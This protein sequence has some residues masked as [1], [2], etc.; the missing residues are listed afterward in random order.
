MYVIETINYTVDLIKNIDIPISIY[1][2]RENNGKYIMERLT[3]KNTDIEWGLEYP[4][5]IIECKD[6]IYHANMLFGE[7]SYHDFPLEK[8]II[9][10]ILKQLIIPDNIDKS[11]LTEIL[12]LIS[13][14]LSRDKLKMFED[15]AQNFTHKTLYKT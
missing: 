8:S 7:V 10:K 15:Y 13:I 4:N 12:I 3:K 5:V 6:S 9:S 1:R 11:L 2:C 14:Q